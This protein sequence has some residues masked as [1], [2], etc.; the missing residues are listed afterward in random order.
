VLFW[1]AANLSRLPDAT[2]ERMMQLSGSG[3]SELKLTPEELEDLRTS[4]AAR[5]EKLRELD[6]VLRDLRQER[7]NLR[8]LRIPELEKRLAEDRRKQER[9]EFPLGVLYQDRSLE[10][11]WARYNAIPAEIR[12]TEQLRRRIEELG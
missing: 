10:Q 5:R 2:V 8:D 11:A 6:R 7:Q 1:G 12:R 4:P 3:S 9:G